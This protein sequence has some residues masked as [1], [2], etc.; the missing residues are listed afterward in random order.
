MPKPPDL[1]F[2]EDAAYS[3]RALD[4]LAIAAYYAGSHD[5]G[6]AALERLLAENRFPASERERIL[7]NQT[8]YQP[9]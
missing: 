1:L 2:I 3:W 9:T 8:H 6:R 5:E 4:E 7:K